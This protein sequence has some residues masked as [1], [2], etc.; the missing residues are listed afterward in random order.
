MRAGRAGLLRLRAA[1]G[2]RLRPRAADV[3]SARVLRGAIVLWEGC[4][5][6]GVGWARDAR[7][8]VPPPKTQKERLPHASKPHVAGC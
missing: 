4:R 5:G 1:G 7:Y 8:S 3:P 2:S 6:V